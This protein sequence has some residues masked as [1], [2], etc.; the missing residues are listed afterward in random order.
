M[1]LVSIWYIPGT[2]GHVGDGLGRGT[3]TQIHWEKTV[4]PFCSLELVK[5]NSPARHSGMG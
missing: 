1:Y 4:S 5:E 3:D 2:V